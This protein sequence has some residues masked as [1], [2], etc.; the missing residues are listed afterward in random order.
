MVVGLSVQVFAN[1]SLLDKFLP[2]I[3]I[4]ND[5][6][7][8]ML[9]VLQTSTLSDEEKEYMCDFFSVMT[10]KKERGDYNYYVIGSSNCTSLSFVRIYRLPFVFALCTYSPTISSNI[11]RIYRFI[12]FSS[13]NNFSYDTVLPILCMTFRF[14]DDTS[15]YVKERFYNVYTESSHFCPIAY[16]AY[17]DVVDSKGWMLLWSS[18]DEITDENLSYYNLNYSSDVSYRL[19]T[20]DEVENITPTYPVGLAFVDDDGLL[21]SFDDDDSTTPDPDTGDEDNENGDSDIGGDSS[22]DSG[23]SA[24]AVDDLGKP[25]FVLPSIDSSNVGY[26]LSAW[27]SVWSAILPTLT[28]VGSIV[29]VISLI[30]LGFEVM[31]TVIKAIVLSF[32]YKHWNVNTNYDYNQS[33]SN[34]INENHNYKH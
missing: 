3:L 22:E 16:M 19:C 5:S 28:K 1:A 9:G 7:L 20:A 31:L 17:N 11:G 24:P 14:K 13:T 6:N 12:P 25:E 33:T 30:I 21:D 23:S 29:F 8:T 32:L 10:G 34:S 26:D 27:D 2:R 4:E 15:L 18:A